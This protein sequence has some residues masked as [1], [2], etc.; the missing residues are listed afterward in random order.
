MH[1][2]HNILQL[3]FSLSRIKDPNEII[4]K[5]V[6]QMQRKFKTI[7]ISFSNELEGIGNEALEIRTKNRSYGY[8]QIGNLSN[9]AEEETELLLDA[10]K[11][12]SVVLE[13]LE[14][15]TSSFGK[16]LAADIS[17][18]KNDELEKTI[19]ELKDAKSASIN[20]VEDLYGE[21]NKRIEAEDELKESESRYRSLFESAVDAL[22]IYRD[23][24]IIEV[25][26]TMLKMY[27]CKRKDVI[28]KSPL[29]FTAEA[30][31]EKAAE[32][33]QS[34]PKDPDEFIA[35]R[36][37]GTT[38]NALVDSKTIIYQ[39]EEARLVA[40]RDISK[41]KIIEQKLIES[42]EKHRALYQN[43]PLS[44]QSLDENGCFID[45]NPMWETTLGF[46]KEEIIDTWFG[47]L[48]HPDYLESFKKN[49][50]E[51]KKRG[52]V[53]NIEFK[54][55]RKNNQYITVLYEGCAGY[56][57][58]GAF[59]QTYCVFKDITKQK[60]AETSLKDKMDE[61][62]R[63]NKLMVGRENQMINLKKEINELCEKLNLQKKYSTPGQLP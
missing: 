33:I 49:F 1:L 21:I 22:V 16:D 35:K 12:L 27:R 18:T 37:D 32:R 3:M 28:G 45:I 51:F 34:S 15:E 26:E 38:F 41:L 4:S 54:L 5:F 11:M 50:P 56:T 53:H 60:E 13:R 19:S 24:E 58:E 17:V 20:L 46:T 2:A 36:P 63:F 25:N 61:L 47:D 29:D 40:I 31:L 42:E 6:S 39:G 7:E 59:R 9:A 8:V 14:F 48:L 62:E 52:S 57:P 55:K 23:N 30:N 10:L 43:A 44:Y